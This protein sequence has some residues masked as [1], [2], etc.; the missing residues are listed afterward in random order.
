[1]SQVAR[2]EGRQSWTEF[3]GSNGDLLDWRENVLRKYY[4]EET[5]SSELAKSTFLFPD[6]V[7]T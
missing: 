7:T 4:R 1:M 6:K 3:V 5:I 2:M